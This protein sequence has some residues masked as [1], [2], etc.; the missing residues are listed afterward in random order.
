MRLRAFS[1]SRAC[2]TVAAVRARRRGDHR[3]LAG[4]RVPVVKQAAGPGAEVAPAWPA[5]VAPGP[6]VSE[7]C[8]RVCPLPGEKRFGSFPV[9]NEME[10]QFGRENELIQKS[11]T[12]SY[13]L[14]IE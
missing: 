10:F 11:I 4:P 12:Y 1:A 13:E 14:Q 7:P 6:H 8:V 2:C 9:L 3:G 5:A